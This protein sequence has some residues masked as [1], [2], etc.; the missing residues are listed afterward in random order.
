MFYMYILGIV[1]VLFTV[2]KYLCHV[3][4]YK[5]L[6][7]TQRQRC[8]RLAR[9]PPLCH[10][11]AWREGSAGVAIVYSQSQHWY[12]QPTNTLQYNTIHKLFQHWRPEYAISYRLKAPPPAPSTHG[13]PPKL[14]QNV[15]IL[16]VCPYSSLLW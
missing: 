5:V 1:D 4:S 6:G 15:V 10:Y 8:S 2:V 13:L 12:A 9:V 7:L 14:T 3:P 16:N 11:C